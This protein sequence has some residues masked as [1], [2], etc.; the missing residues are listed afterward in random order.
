MKASAE[1]KD[2]A[3]KAPLDRLRDAAKVSK[4]LSILTTVDGLSQSEHC[5]G[6]I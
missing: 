6:L 1:Q 5:R 4:A 2:A 3:H